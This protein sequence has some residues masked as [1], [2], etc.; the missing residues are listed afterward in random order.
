MAFTV[1]I[2]EDDDFLTPNLFARPLSDYGG[3]FDRPD[4]YYAWKPIYQVLGP[5]W[6]EN[7]DRKIKE[8]HVGRIKLHYEFMKKCSR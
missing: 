6:F 7:S 3:M 4:D 5:C 2:L 1:E 8:L